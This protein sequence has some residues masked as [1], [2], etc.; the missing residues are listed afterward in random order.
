M[1][2]TAGRTKHVIRIGVH[3]SIAGGLSLSVERAAA[4]KC[5]TMQIFSHSPRQWKQGIIPQ[6]E[7]ERFKTL[8]R[9][10]DIAPVFV[11]ASYL[12]NLAS[13]SNS[14]LEKS[15]SLLAYELRNADEI[16][17]EY[18]IVH[19][20]SAGAE[21]GKT[22]RSRA[23][24]AIAQALDTGRFRAQLVLEN[25][26]GE[27]GDITSSIESLAEIMEGCGRDEI[28]GICID[29]CHAFAAGYD[30]RTRK[31]TDRLASAVL[32]Y[33]GRKGLKLIHVNDS[34]KPLGS[35]VDRHEHIGQGHIGLQ[36][37]KTLFAD[38]RLSG[39]PLILET[40]KDSDDADRR[41]LRAIRRILAGKGQEKEWTA[42]PGMSR[43]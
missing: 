2:Q 39:I 31:G 38:A 23:V 37:F 15:I 25:T 21:D 6:E 34:K 29:T 8:R 35:G 30:L 33:I 9:Q 12:I 16:G 17:A 3:T 24:Q 41:N 18:V 19:T 7:A 14:V 11:H 5:S 28:G 4:L 22:T 42:G 13:L 32:S 20:G 26:A 10:Y 43:P 36:G 40:P 1:K 27:R